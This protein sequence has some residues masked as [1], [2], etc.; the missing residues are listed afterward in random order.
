MSKLVNFFNHL[1]KRE[2]GQTLSEYALILVLVVVVV[3][4]VLGLLGGQIQAVFTQIVNA[5]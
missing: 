1:F 3:I 5:L 2:E 4:V